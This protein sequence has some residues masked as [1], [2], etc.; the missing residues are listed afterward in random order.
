MV[1]SRCIMV[2][3]AELIKLGFNPTAVELGYAK[4]KEELPVATLAVVDRSLKEFGFELLLDRK[5]QMVE[6]IKNAIILLVHQNDA[7]LA[8][9]LSSYLSD[10]LQ[11][12][13]SSLSSIFSEVEAQTIEKY[14][15]SQKIERV[16]EMLSY[17]D[18]TLSEIANQL[19]YSSVAH[20]SGQFKKVTGQT[21]ST[22]KKTLNNRLSLDVI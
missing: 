15:I 16:K 14:Y 3:K 22:F 18:L 11:A 5:N 12:D 10:L 21:P 19:N 1:C 7:I 9:N 8:E 4:L 13:Y 6:Q 2:V 20:L 17:G